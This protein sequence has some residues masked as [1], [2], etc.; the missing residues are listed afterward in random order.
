VKIQ[1][2]EQIV[3]LARLAPTTMPRSKL[4]RSPFFPILTF[5]LELQGSIFSSMAGKGLRLIYFTVMIEEVGFVP[6]IVSFSS[7]LF[8]YRL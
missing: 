6:S 3:K 1:V 8:F 2:T 7:Y 4:L 5:S